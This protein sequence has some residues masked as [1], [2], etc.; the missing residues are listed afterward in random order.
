MENTRYKILLIED[1]QLDQMAFKRFVENNTI[2]YDCTISGSVSNAKQVL[3]SDEQFDIIITDHSLGDGTAFDILELAKNTP[4]IV[5]TGAGDEE[6]A[7]KAW[8]AGAYDYLVKDIN[9]NYLKAIPITVENAVRHDKVEKELQLLSGAVMST[10]DSIYI[11]DMQGKIIYINKAFCKTYG[12]KE[13]EI[14]GQNGNLLWI[15]KHQSQ[16]TRSVFQSKTSRSG[17]EVGFYHRRK[18]NSVFPVSLSRSNIK[19]SKGLDVA[20]VG[21][22]RDITERI[23]I[24][25]ELRTKSE[26]LRKKM[27]LQNDMTT[28]VTETLQRLLDDGNIET[29]KRVVNDYFDISN[30]DANKVELNKQMFDF[31][32]LISQ[33]VEAF[34]P[35]AN[36]KNIDLKNDV[37]DCELIVNAD[38]DRIAQVLINLLSRAIKFSPVNGRVSLRV[39]DTDDELRV[40]I[41]DEGQ[42]LERNEIQRIINRPDLIKEQFNTGREDL[43]LGLRIAK[44][45]IE[46][47]GGQIWAQSSEDK[48]NICCFTVPKSSARQESN[49]EMSSADTI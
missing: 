13:E 1:D 26:N 8:K 48:Q 23:I 20:I 7:I 27:Q 31:T 4:V 28:L 24:E 19:D 43:I 12:Y 3:N 10:D 49:M 16:N 38:Y 18:D 29:A 25:D 35:L 33:A 5:V 6:T 44:E 14:V 9:Q 11:T 2:P 37:P 46:M 45:F 41:Q 17:W 22:A 30:I 32:S 42:L 15:G 34:M 40:E 36:E 47:H 39:E 21:V